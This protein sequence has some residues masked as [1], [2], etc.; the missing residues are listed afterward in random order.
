MPNIRFSAKWVKSL[1]PP[2]SGQVDYFDTNRLVD[3]RNFGLRVSYGGRKTWF[4]MYRHNGKLRR[5]KIGTYPD[6]GLAGAREAADQ[7]VK[8]I[9]ERRD[10]AAERQSRKNARTFGQL[11]DDYLE[12]YAKKKKRSWSR[13]KEI[14]ERELLPAWRDEKARDITRRDVKN[15]LDGIID[16]A[17]PVMANRT[18]AV[19]RKIFNWGIDIDSLDPLTPTYYLD[20]NPSARMGQL[21]PAEHARERVL[22][23]AEIKTLWS[24]LIGGELTISWP[25]VL[26]LQ[27]ILVTAQRKGEVVGI[28]KKDVDLKS[29]WWTIPGYKTKN[30]HTHRVALSTLAVELVTEAM[31]LSGE[32]GYVFPSP[33]DPDSPIL[34]TAVDFAVRR[35]R[36]AFG[37][38]RWTPHD[39]RRTAASSMTAS[40]VSR[41]LLAK[42]LNHTDRSVTAVYDRHS[43]DKEKRRALNAWGWRL[44]GIVKGKKAKVVELAG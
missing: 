25:V 35:N 10:P 23:P 7:E 3:N 4:V 13:D 16:R 42:I 9:I 41:D 12:Q 17:A 5:L 24:R 14:I 22:S 29:A 43:Y 34:D 44:E 21:M 37:L 38:E 15:L 31:E 11:A 20:G 19:M 18:L 32:S 26:V 1:S 6:L 27:L 40:G 39:L 36:S 33:R 30:G 8:A 28:A 2:P